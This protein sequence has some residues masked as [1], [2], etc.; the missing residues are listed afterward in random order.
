VIT[1]MVV[2]ESD[3]PIKAFYTTGRGGAKQAST[4]RRGMQKTYSSNKNALDQGVPALRML[5]EN[6]KFRIAWAEETRELVSLWIGEMTSFS[7][8]QGKL[9][10][11]GAHDDTVMAL[12]MADRAAAIGDA[13]DL[14]DETGSG[15]MVGDVPAVAPAD[16][17]PND[18]S[19]T[20]WFGLGA[21]DE[22]GGTA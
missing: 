16:D 12:W 1:D 8:A 17:Y 13:F 3:V 14:V 19:G 18:G 7:W 2:Q 11:V 6:G 9:Q 10:G 22:V 4:M 20:D 5:L 21:V 15:D